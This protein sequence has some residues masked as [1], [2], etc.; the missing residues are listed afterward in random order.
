MQRLS[1]PNGVWKTVCP[2][3]AKQ[4][5][6]PTQGTGAPGVRPWC[7]PCV[8]TYMRP[9]TARRP[10]NKSEMV[11]HA[12]YVRR[13]MAWTVVNSVFTVVSILYS[14]NNYRATNSRLD[15]PA[16][17][18]TSDGQAMLD[19]VSVSTGATKM[20]VMDVAPDKDW[21]DGATAFLFPLP[22]PVGSISPR[23][24]PGTDHL[25]QHA[26][27]ALKIGIVPHGGCHAFWKKKTS[28]KIRTHKG[29]LRL[30]VPRAPR[31]A[32]SASKPPY[33]VHRHGDQL[34][35]LVQG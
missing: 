17:L 14:F 21:E 9:H 20:R 7:V 29:L 1:S 15:R 27:T 12:L 6:Q 32:T 35:R 13:L 11:W 24:A 34:A 25:L 22:D 31:R 33:P 30:R 18:G 26:S 23:H 10:T 4:I 3:R 2:P 8:Y 16:A 5:A 19:T 28:I